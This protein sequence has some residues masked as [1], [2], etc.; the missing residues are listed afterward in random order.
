VLGAM[1]GLGGGLMGSIGGMAAGIGS[2]LF[3]ADEGGARPADDPA[4]VHDALGE[5]RPMES[6]VRGRMERAFGRPFSGVR[7]HTDATAG[8]LS[9]EQNARAFAVGGHVAFAA[10][11][12]RPGTPAGDALIAHEL[13]HTVQQGSGA[14]ATQAKSASGD[15]Y[16]ALEADADRS[17][18]GVVARL[19]S[20]AKAAAGAAALNAGPALRSG[21]SLQRCSKN[22][23]KTNTPGEQ[24]AKVP[25]KPEAPG[26]VAAP[27][28]TKTP[29]EPVK[30]PPEPVDPEPAEWCAKESDE[31][32]LLKLIK[33][34]GAPTP[35]GKL[36]Y[37][38][39]WWNKGE[40]TKLPG[41]G[42]EYTGKSATALTGHVQKTTTKFGTME[43]LYLKAGTHEVPGKKFN[44]TDSQCG[45]DG[46]R[47]PLFSAVSDEMSLL[48]RRAE[49]EHCNDYRRAFEL[50]Y[51]QE[52]ANINSLVGTPFGPGTKAQVR[53]MVEKA[54]EAK[55]DKGHQGWVNEINR[56]VRISQTV[57]DDGE[58]H[59]LDSDGAPQKV[60]DKCTR[61][62][63]TTVKARTTKIPGP[64]TVD[65]IK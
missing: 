65:I 3:K 14:V 32:G 52:A 40:T 60:D 13:A 61:K 15:N 22:K 59:R 33:K 6:G 18:A 49:Q 16:G 39:T 20:G 8:R 58:L 26:D 50:T 38:F 34:A 30:P 11:E 10:G 55:G 46:K 2:L 24:P 48:A 62:D 64:R 5:G 35:V 28:E 57:R 53:A 54:L 36:S 29:P 7:M 56:L 21:L 12:Y 45:P 31:A 47:V 63:A 41:L 23:A 43:A 19:W 37:G 27:A 51:V 1:A 25:P 9:R 42:I 17:A 4:A 44:V